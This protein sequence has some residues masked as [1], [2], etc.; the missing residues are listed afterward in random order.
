MGII[1]DVS[2][3]GTH[4]IE[5]RKNFLHLKEYYDRINEIEILLKKEENNNE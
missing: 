2:I 5:E 3:F 4:C 1:E